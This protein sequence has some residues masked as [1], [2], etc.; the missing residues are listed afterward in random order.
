MS[1]IQIDR[2]P[3]NT[4][5]LY[6]MLFSPFHRNIFYSILHQKFIKFYNLRDLI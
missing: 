2:N 3:Y 6:C 4:N 5:I 1:S